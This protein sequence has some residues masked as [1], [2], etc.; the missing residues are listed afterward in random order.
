V[1]IQPDAGY[2]PPED[3]SE[4]PSDVGLV[5][6][7]VADEDV[8]RQFLHRGLRGSARPQDV[9]AEWSA[10]V[11]SKSTARSRP[12]AAYP[13]FLPKMFFDTIDVQVERRCNGP[14]PAT[15]DLDC[16]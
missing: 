8:P 15:L 1:V 11:P 7:G 14:G 13:P 16:I 9:D 4:R 5:L 3:V 12:D 6:A 2:C 10:P